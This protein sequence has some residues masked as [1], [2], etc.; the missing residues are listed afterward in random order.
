[1]A[2]N[3]YNPANASLK[4][5]AYA[6]AQS[7][8]MAQ[9]STTSS[10]F[11]TFAHS[12][13]T[14]TDRFA[15]YTANRAN[16]L[17]RMTFG[18]PQIEATDAAPVVPKGAEL[19]LETRFPYLS[20]DQRR[21]VLKTTELPSGYPVM[22]DAEGWG[23]LNMFAAADGYGAF[24]GNVIVSMDA[25]QGGFNALD[26][27]RNPISGTGKLTLQGTGTLRLAGANTFSGGSQIAGGTLEA[28][29]GAALGTGDVY[30]G[31]GSLVVN[32]PGVVSVVGKF[33]Q[34]ANTTLELNLGTNGQGS[35]KVGAQTT[36]LGGTL[37]VKF[38]DGFK[39]KAGDTITVISGNG[40]NVK[41]SAVSVD[42]FKATPV[43]SST[44]VQ[45]H[46]DS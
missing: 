10:T 17:R 27:W 18:F 31:A 22:D 9:T 6:Q 7:A 23:R 40:S 34:L 1:V 14:A 41:F 20:A 24:N 25:T 11:N 42:G 12:G 19:L 30:L 32:A 43:Y 15:D 39:P 8:L 16:Y 13:T 37:H 35:M 36:V 2:A 45:V 21:V 29:S 5:A 28:D 4:A 3:L 44:G 38:V 33:T 26:T 46:L